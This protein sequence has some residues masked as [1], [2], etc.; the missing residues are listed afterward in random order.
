METNVR[1]IATELVIDRVGF[2]SVFGHTRGSKPYL[3]GSNPEYDCLLR[4]PVL[5]VNK[6][7]LSKI[8]FEEGDIIKIQISRIGK[9]DENKQG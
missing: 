2:M 3:F 5:A 9:Q 7:E 8:I 1:V 4:L 6:D